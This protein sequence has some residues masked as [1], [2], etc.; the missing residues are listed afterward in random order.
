MCVK[1]MNAEK[2]MT[3]M[4]ALHHRIDAWRRDEK[5][6]S[7]VEFALI[8]PMMIT[9]YIGAVEFSHAL[10]IDRRVTSVASAAADLVAQS[11]EVDDGALTDIFTASTSIMM[12]YN[13]GP[14]S[15]V[16]T[17]VV[18][19]EDNDTTV[20]WSAAHN[21][22]AYAEDADYTVPAGLT[23]PFSSV[24][25]AE[26]SYTYE[27]PVGQFLTGGIDM[28]DTFYLRPRRSLTVEKTDGDCND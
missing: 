10:T 11:E 19:D 24:I 12:P 6:I 22:A 9:M 5:G 8:L 23:Q 13:A 14:I 27:P 20:C 25:V 21:G 7:A 16:L 18:A 1:A 17:S 28:T 4:A 26:V 15:I 2:Q 3:L